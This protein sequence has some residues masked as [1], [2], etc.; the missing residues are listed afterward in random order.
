MQCFPTTGARGR[1]AC[2]FSPVMP[3]YL[4]F[5]CPSTTTNFWSWVGNEQLWLWALWLLSQAWIT[6][7]IWSPKSPRLAATEKMFGTP[8]YCGL[9]IDQSMVLNRRRDGGEDVKIVKSKDDLGVGKVYEK[10]KGSVFYYLLHLGNNTS[11][12]TCHSL[13]ENSWS[14][15]SSSKNPRNFATYWCES[16]APSSFS[17][18]K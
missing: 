3:E 13:A 10:V 9:F 8:Y 5:D 15:V 1:D 14:E 16:I 6:R 2:A 17:L 4:F 7:H 18:S 12:L 11:S